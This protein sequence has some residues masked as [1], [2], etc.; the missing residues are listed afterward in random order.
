MLVTV[1]VAVMPGAGAARSAAGA[2]SAGQELHPGIRAV[3]FGGTLAA[4]FGQRQ[5]QLS[6]ATSAGPYLILSTAGYADGRPEVPVSSDTYI[7]QEMTSLANGI[8][9]AVGAP[10]GVPPPVPRCPGAP[11]C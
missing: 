10:L 2:L 5:Q 1:G 6:W 11:G 3:A 4:S 7:D 9:D 8:A